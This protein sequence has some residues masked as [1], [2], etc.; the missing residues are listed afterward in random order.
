MLCL[1]VSK[2]PPRGNTA[3]S[4]G[5][6]VGLC[7]YSGPPPPPGILPSDLNALVGVVHMFALV[8]PMLHL[9]RDV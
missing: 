3:V 1:L 4:L 6:L 8:Q 9:E 7:W 5:M 2:P